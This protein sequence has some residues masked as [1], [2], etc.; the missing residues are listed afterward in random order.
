MTN[1]SQ[2]LKEYGMYIRKNRDGTYSLGILHSGRPGGVAAFDSY[3]D[4]YSAFEQIIDRFWD[5][6]MD[7]LY[8][9]IDSMGIGK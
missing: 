7:N 9:M 5:Y 8:Q 6:H 2:R 1:K 3:D 4:A